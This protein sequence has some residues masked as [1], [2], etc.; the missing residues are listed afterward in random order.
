MVERN[1]RKSDVENERT[2]HDHPVRPPVSPREAVTPESDSNLQP[3]GTSPDHAN[4]TDGYEAYLKALG[5]TN[6]IFVDGLFG[7]ILGGTMRDVAAS[8]MQQF[9]FRMSVVKG[10]KPRDE[11]EAMLLAQMGGTHGALMRLFE[12]L[13]RTD[14][15]VL[16]ESILR[17][18]TQLTRTYTA[19]FE[20]FK[21]YRNGGEKKV[22]IQNVSVADGGQAAIVGTMAQASNEN[23]ATPTMPALPDARPTPMEIIG[24]AAR[25]PVP[26]RPAKSKK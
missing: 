4:E 5:T 6:P 14:D 26:L 23:V 11:L 21:R 22:T 15:P 17:G 1:T 18:I 10:M 2:K 19:Q 12:Q 25:V 20:V 24:E 13:Y 7:P 9:G 16:Q 3:S 8:D